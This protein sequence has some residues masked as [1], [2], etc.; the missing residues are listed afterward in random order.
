MCHTMFWCD[1]SILIRLTV[2]ANELNEVPQSGISFAPS[3][4]A[5][6]P[7]KALYAGDP[8]RVSIDL[9][10]FVWLVVCLHH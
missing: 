5:G 1:T 2:D 4:D 9:Y 3:P 6:A 8:S 10:W 7:A